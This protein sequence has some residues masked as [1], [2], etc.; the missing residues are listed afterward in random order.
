MSTPSLNSLGNDEILNFSLQNSDVNEDDG[1]QF[2]KSLLS[3]ST[4][5][6]IVSYLTD[7]DN[8]SITKVPTPAESIYVWL[9]NQTRFHE[10]LIPDPTGLRSLIKDTPVKWAV[11]SVL[12]TKCFLSIATIQV[13]LA[14]LSYPCSRYAIRRAL[15]RCEKFGLVEITDGHYEGQ[16]LHYRKT[17]KHIKWRTTLK[18]RILINAPRKIMKKESLFDKIRV[19]LANATKWMVVSEIANSVVCSAS[20]ARKNLRKNEDLPTQPGIFKSAKVPGDHHGRTQWA[21]QSND[22]TGWANAEPVKARVKPSNKSQTPTGNP[23]SVTQPAMYGGLTLMCV[24][25]NKTSL[26]KAVGDLLVEEFVTSGKKFSAY[27]VTKKLR[28]KVLERAKE[29]NS[30]FCS[31]AQFVDV[32]ET[33]TVH[34]QGLDVPKIEHDDVKSIVHEIFNAGG[35]PGLGRVHTK[36]ASGNYWEYD[37]KAN[38]DAYTASPGP[39]VNV[40]GSTSEPDPIIGG[41]MG[42]TYDGSSTI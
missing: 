30:P 2:K 34:V 11:L 15:K 18:G 13:L 40:T 38:I 5:P 20:A 22:T 41:T 32:Q 29:L 31:K 27:D 12:S 4:L 17:S 25:I 35:M 19:E 33:G 14:G 6:L 8:T 24:P 26:I 3:L 23:V 9:L 42:S 28:E 21:L 1:T 16:L 36:D 37:T 39:T 10:Q 7:G